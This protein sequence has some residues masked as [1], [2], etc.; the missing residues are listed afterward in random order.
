MG[1]ENAE[2]SAVVGEH[3]IIGIV[4]EVVL[5]VK[6]ERDVLADG[7]HVDDRA[8]SPVGV[9]CAGLVVEE[10]AGT[11]LPGVGSGAR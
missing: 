3:V 7:R 6:V 8:L 1:V 5:D 10:R 4:L 2:Q 11:R 9:T